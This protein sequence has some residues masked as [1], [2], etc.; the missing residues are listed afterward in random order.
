ME[1]LIEQREYGEKP[2]DFEACQR[3][4]L[5]C[6]WKKI[7]RGEPPVH[8]RSVVNIFYNRDIVSRL[9]SLDQT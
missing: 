4:T 5:V 1:R 7:A 6:R 3:E 2:Q 8:S 9:Y